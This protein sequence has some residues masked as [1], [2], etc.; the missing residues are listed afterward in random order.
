MSKCG[1]N[2]STVSHLGSELCEEHTTELLPYLSSMDVMKT[3]M[4]A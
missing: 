3:M 1:H 4:A 2:V